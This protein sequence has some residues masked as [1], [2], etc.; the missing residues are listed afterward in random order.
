MEK[1]TE[2][3]SVLL[4]ATFLLYFFWGKGRFFP[5]TEI[6]DGIIPIS[7]YIKFVKMSSY[8]ER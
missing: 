7:V 4:S 8:L 5:V 6:I 2:A 1:R 3:F